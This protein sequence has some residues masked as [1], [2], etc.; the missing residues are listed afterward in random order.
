MQKIQEIEKWSPLVVFD[1]TNK[2]LRDELPYF[3]RKSSSDVQREIEQLQSPLRER[4]AHF[5]KD[6]LST[7]FV[8]ILSTLVAIYRILLTTI[9]RERALGIIQGLIYERYQPAGFLFARFGITQKAPDKAFE[10]IKRNP[11]NVK[12]VFS[13]E[14]TPKV[15]VSDDT[16]FVYGYDKCFFDE[17]F[18]SNDAPEMLG[19][20]CSLD[21]IWASELEKPK[22]GGLKCDYTPRGEK[23]PFCR[24][25]ITKI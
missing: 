19:V 7:K 8:K 17:F 14:F 23:K 21:S 10:M 12:K 13:K 3:L 20:F 5:V 25:L 16:Q 18:R 6:E 24:F 9:N 11:E 15:E 4:S 22:Y 1:E 2:V